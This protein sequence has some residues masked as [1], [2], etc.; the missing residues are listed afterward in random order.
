[1]SLQDFSGLDINIILSKPTF[2]PA[3][4]VEPK[5]KAFDFAYHRH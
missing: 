2:Y 3:L 5:K 4:I 1:M